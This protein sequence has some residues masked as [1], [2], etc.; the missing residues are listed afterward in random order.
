MKNKVLVS[1]VT[2]AYNSEN[3]IKDTIESV[4]NQT[5]QNIE[6]WIIDGNSTDRTVKIAE[7]YRQEFIKKGIKFNIISEPDNGIYDA[8][9]K[10]VK[11][12][13]GEIVGLINSDDWYEPDAV[14][15]VIKCYE[16]T[17]FDMMYADLN[18]VKKSGVTVKHSRLRKYVSSRDWNHPTTFITKQMYN[19]YQYKVKNIYDDFDLA[20]RIKKDDNKVV[21]LNEVLANFR[22]G[23]VSNEKNFKKT[24]NRMK[25]RYEVYRCNGLSRFYLFECVGVELAKYFID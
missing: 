4:L 24:V 25:A 8:M 17:S 1:I 7:E 18:I 13:N 10:G 20:I 22:F 16:N 2:V 23:G 9:N 15:K 21:V 19:K 14:E 6:Y 11:H 3:T 5:Y 12:S